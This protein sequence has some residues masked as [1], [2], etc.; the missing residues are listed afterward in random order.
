[1]LLYRLIRSFIYQKS[2]NSSKKNLDEGF[3]RE[4][5]YNH[6]GCNVYDGHTIKSQPIGFWTK[7][8]VLRYKVEHKIPI[9]CIYGEVVCNE[10]GEW[11]T[12]GEKRTGCIMCG[13]GCHLEKKPNR[14]QRLR[15]SKNPV[16][17]RMCEGILKIENHG[18][19][20]EEAL[21]RCHIAT[22]CDEALK[23]D[24]DKRKTA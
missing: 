4:N 2:W 18:V 19:T 21:Q 3:K 5:Q 1:M 9:C 8:D 6:T 22:E 24:G 13:F 23:D 7:E 16:H 11:D 20:Y 14:I 12:T 15:C 10:A 17:R